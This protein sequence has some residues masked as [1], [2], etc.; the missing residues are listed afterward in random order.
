MKVT[1]IHPNLGHTEGEISSEQAMMEPLTLGVLAGLTPPEIDLAMFD[2][3]ME[4]IPFDEPTD[5]VAI[6]VQ[7]FT[8]KRAY[9]IG[10]AYRQRGVKVILGGMHPTLLPQEAAAFADSVFIGDAESLWPSV[11]RDAQ[12]GALKRIYRGVPGPPQP[13]AITRRDLFEGRGYLPVTL[14][15][16]GR[17]C[18]Y[19]CTFCAVNTFFKGHHHVRD[20]REVVREIEAQERRLLFFV[21]DNLIADPEAAKRLFRALI[22]LRIRWVS[23]MTIEL[24]R[25]AELMDLMVESGCL[26]TLIGFESL[27][28]KNLK[29]VGKAA[30]LQGFARY[31]PQLD[32]LRAY[33]VQIWAAFVLGFDE[34]TPETIDDTLAFALENRFVFA[35]FNLL[36]PYPNT[37]LYRRFE[38]EGRLLYDGRWWLH[39]D[40]K[41]NH[42]AFIPKQMS[43]EA[44]T[45]ACFNARV[46]FNSPGSILRRA[47][48]PSNLRSLFRVA[49]FFSYAPL[50][51]REIYRKQGMTLGTGS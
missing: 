4:Q 29:A 42:A 47:L 46:K 49:T 5:L 24:V 32:V 11:L 8:A 23:Q 1:L 33:G 45:E 31:Q 26:G 10:S 6:N 43:P 41:F 37:S 34:D 36:T 13:G 38:E 16:F 40:Y 21:D 27:D 18:H 44:L 25:D 51:R 17:G 50:F 20:V 35:A 2:D 9:E 19:G 7:S 3:R 30:N 39:P 12:R 14:L 28:P 22:P 48:E 15:Q